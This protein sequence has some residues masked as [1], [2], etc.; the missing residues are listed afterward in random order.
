MESLSGIEEFD[1]FI[2]N[3]DEELGESEKLL[4]LFTAFEEN[5]KVF[6]GL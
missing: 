5:R 4:R 1:S 3:L 6:E 2:L